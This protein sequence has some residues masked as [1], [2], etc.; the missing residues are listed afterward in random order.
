[1]GELLWLLGLLFFKFSKKFV[2]VIV[3]KILVN[4]RS[5][6]LKVLLQGAVKIAQIRTLCAQIPYKFSIFFKKLY[7]IVAF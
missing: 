1:M 2:L 5:V 4:K 7:V 3:F 6:Y